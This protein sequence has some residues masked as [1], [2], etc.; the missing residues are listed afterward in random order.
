MCIAFLSLSVSLISLALSVSCERVFTKVWVRM[1]ISEH[2]EVAVMC[3]LLSLSILLTEA[4][5]YLSLE[6]LIQLV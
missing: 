5:Y 3:L 4:A 6:N 1:H 2:V